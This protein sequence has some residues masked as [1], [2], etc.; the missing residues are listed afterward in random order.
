[1]FVVPGGPVQIAIA[2]FIT[3]VFFALSMRFTPFAH[4][5]HDIVKMLSEVTIFIVLLSV[6]LMKPALVDSQ[7]DDLGMGTVAAIL[8][9]SCLIVFFTARAAHQVI[10]GILKDMH[11]L[12]AR[13]KGTA[14]HE[15]PMTGD[16]DEDTPKSNT[17]NNTLIEPDTA[18]KTGITERD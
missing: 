12:E 10:G 7:Q 9:L 17:A 18:S 16:N 4:P 1:M 3:F 6:L 13:A 2:M 11:D 8:S 15:N 14:T 5:A